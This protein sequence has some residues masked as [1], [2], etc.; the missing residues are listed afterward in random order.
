MPRARAS[1]TM[2][3]DR[4]I[5]FTS[6]PTS[7]TNRS[8]SSPGP[9]PLEQVGQPPVEVLEAAVEVDR[10]VA[11]APETVGLDEV[12]EDEPAVEL[13]QQLLGR[14]DAVDVRFRR[15]RLVDVAARKDVADLADA[16]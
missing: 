1:S 4:S 14:L 2:R 11:V 3:I 9:Q 13:L 12:R 6:A 8:V 7:F 10:I 5:A 15:V 16:V